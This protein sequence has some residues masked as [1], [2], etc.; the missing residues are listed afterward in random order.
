M[1]QVNKS[2]RQFCYYNNEPFWLKMVDDPE[3]F[4]P[5]FITSFLYP[6]HPTRSHVVVQAFH[7]VTGI[8][9]SARN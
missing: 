6:P 2:R 8:A 4:K 7:I 3:S 9:H 5:F 1:Y